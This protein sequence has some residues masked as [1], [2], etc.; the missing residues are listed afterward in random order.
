M[1]GT[2]QK[3]LVTPM[4]MLESTGVESSALK[5]RVYVFALFVISKNRLTDN[6]TRKDQVESVR[7]VKIHDDYMTKESK[8]WH[9]VCWS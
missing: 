2:D 7:F 3:T 1:H 6:T 9:G 8:D 4:D 5:I